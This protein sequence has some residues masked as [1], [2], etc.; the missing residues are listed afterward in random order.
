MQV[1]IFP[2][3][4]ELILQNGD[5]NIIHKSENLMEATKT[6]DNGTICIRMKRE[7]SHYSLHDRHRWRVSFHFERGIRPQRYFDS[8]KVHDFA[9][10]YIT[11]YAVG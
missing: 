9:K 2:E 6:F 10:N 3:Q 4:F 11:P 8:K 7:N 5:F 1:K